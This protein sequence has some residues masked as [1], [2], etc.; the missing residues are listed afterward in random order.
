MGEIEH[1]RQLIESSEFLLVAEEEVGMKTRTS[2]EAT[3]KK[4]KIFLKD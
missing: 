1:R 3:E 2:T 4:I